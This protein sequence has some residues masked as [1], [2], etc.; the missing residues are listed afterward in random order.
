MQLHNHLFTLCTIPCD[1][2][3]F[4][5]TMGSNSRRKASIAVRSSSTMTTLYFSSV[6]IINHKKKRNRIYTDTSVPVCPSLLLVILKRIYH[7]CSLYS[8]I[9]WSDTTLSILC[10][11]PCGGNY[12]RK[13][14]ASVV[15]NRYANPICFTG[16]IYH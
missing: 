2:F 4:K 6:S 1:S 12:L 15:G 10:Q 13:I 16:N 14:P 8:V 7:S 5:F 3:Y 11:S 9:E